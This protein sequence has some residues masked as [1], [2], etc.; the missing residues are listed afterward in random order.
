MF[1]RAR[2]CA[3][4]LLIAGC[5][6]DEGL[7]AGP[8]GDPATTA[9]ATTSTTGAT[10][11]TTS[12]A[13][14]TTEA[15]DAT[16]STSTTANPTTTGPDQCGQTGESCGEG[17][18]GCLTCILGMCLPAGACGT[19]EVCDF[20]GECVLSPGASCGNCQVCND[21]GKCLLAP[22]ADC[23]AADNPCVGQIWGIDEDTCHAYAPAGTCDA[24]GTCIPKSTCDEPGKELASC[25]DASCVVASACVADKPVDAVGDFCATDGPTAD[26]ATTCDDGVLD[27]SLEV[28]QCGPGGGCMLI[29]VSDCGPY[30]CDGPSAC[31]TSCA[32]DDECALEFICVAGACTSR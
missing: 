19:C 17:C 24:D 31:K 4:V 32:S 20:T 7:T 11:G 14:V 23:E 16:T 6:V 29:N 9:T 8:T 18:C 22:G 5:F 25:D 21:N 30:R 1:D 28:R 27:S 2:A 3:L 10:T 13:A 12:G 26:C 15:S